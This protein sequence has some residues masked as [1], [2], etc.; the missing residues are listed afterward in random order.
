M[1]ASL[2]NTPTTLV[3]R[4]RDLTTDILAFTAFSPSYRCKIWSN[5]PLE[6][7][8]EQIKRR[9]RVV[10]IFPNYTNSLPLI[11]V[12]LAD[13]HDEWAVARRYLTLRSFHGRTQPTARH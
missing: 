8:N 7:A 10:G 12:I 2:G 9:A 6:R 13:Q 3:R 5:N 1:A 11:G 4:L